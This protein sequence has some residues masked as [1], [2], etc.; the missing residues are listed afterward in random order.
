MVAG[1]AT[2]NDRYAELTQRRC[3]SSSAN[4]RVGRGQQRRGDS[5][6]SCEIL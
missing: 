4:D 5:S 3:H 6:A 1:R 2:G